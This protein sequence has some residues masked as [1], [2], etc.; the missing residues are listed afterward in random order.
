ME[1]LLTEEIIDLFLIATTFSIILMTFMQ[2]VKRLSFVRNDGHI[3]ILNLLFS[4]SIGTLFSMTF[5]N[6]DLSKSL[7]VGFFSFIGAP[8]V[9]QIMKQQN[10][11][12]Y[13]PKALDNNKGKVITIPVENEI[14]RSN[15]GGD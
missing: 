14:P 2:K 13:K 7:W 5:Y 6:L 10:I 15:N 4:L 1:I 8:T 9:Y 11:I 12:N 3:C